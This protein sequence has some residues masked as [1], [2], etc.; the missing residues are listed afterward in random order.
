MVSPQPVSA[1]TTVEKHGNCNRQTKWYL[2]LSGLGNQ[3]RV[4]FRGDS[5]SPTG[6]NW[7]IVAYNNNRKIFDSSVTTQGIGD[8]RGLRNM[9]FDNNNNNIKQLT[10]DVDDFVDDYTKDDDDDYIDGDDNVDEGVHFVASFSTANL[11]GRDAISIK[12][13]ASRTKEVCQTNIVYSW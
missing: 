9:Y 7:K 6:Q 12:A 1:I 2:K 5:P 3:I 10:D 8:S 4:S 11:N 13:T